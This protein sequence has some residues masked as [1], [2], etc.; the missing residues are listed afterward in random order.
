MTFTPRFGASWPTFWMR[1]T[2]LAGAASA[3]LL[4]QATPARQGKQYALKS[5]EGL[6]L[7]NVAAEPAGLEG[8]EGLRVTMSEETVRRFKDMTPAEQA[9][10]QAR[11]GQYAIIDGLE[12]ANGVIEV[13]TNGLGNA[14]TF[15]I[16]NSASA[17]NTI[18]STT[19]GTSPARST[20]RSTCHPPMCNRSLRRMLPMPWLM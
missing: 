4:A 17:A 20:R 15:S 16:T 2:L 13:T 9:T 3:T 10:E 7:H 18:A 1:F 8:K 6:R 11:V 12:F 5:P 14:G 19:A